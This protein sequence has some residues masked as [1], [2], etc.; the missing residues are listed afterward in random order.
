M[1]R[2]RPFSHIKAR[3]NTGRLLTCRLSTGTVSHRDV[4][5]D[6]LC[7]SKAQW[8]HYLSQSSKAFRHPSSEHIVAE[9]A[10]VSHSKGTYN[11]NVLGEFSLNITPVFQPSIRIATFLPVHLHNIIIWPDRIVVNNL[12]PSDIP[13]LF[14]FF[15]KDEQI[16]ISR[17]QSLLSPGVIIK[18]LEDYVILCATTPFVSPKTSQRILGWFKQ[19]MLSVTLK[20]TNLLLAANLGGH[21]ESTG[22]YVLP[23]DDSFVTIDSPSKAGAILERYATAKQT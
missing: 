10:K 8:D 11:F 13:I 19:A 20:S 18:N 9:Y 22:I 1:Y 17:L 14:N 6:D 4:F 7:C 12:T 3:V 16:Q 21:R 23:F 15:V 2:I 5:V